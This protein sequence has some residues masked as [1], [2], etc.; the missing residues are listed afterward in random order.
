MELGEKMDLEN[1]DLLEK[2]HQD[3]LTVLEEVG[4]HCESPRIRQIFEETGLAAVDESTGHIHVLAPLVEQAL[5]TAPKRGEYWIPENSFGV[6][7][8]APFVYD[9]ETGEL[10]EPTFEHL[11]RIAKIVDEADASPDMQLVARQRWQQRVKSLGLDPSIIAEA[12]P[13]KTSDPKSAEPSD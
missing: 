8:T 13:Q 4:V 2:I 11:V 6:G 10:I 9:D 3:A 1:S 5:T 7:G 12:E